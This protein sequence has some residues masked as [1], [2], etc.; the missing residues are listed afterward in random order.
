MNYVEN[1]EL[2]TIIMMKIKKYYFYA[3]IV[4]FF[5]FSLNFVIFFLCKF[6]AVSNFGS[7][8][9]IIKIMLAGFNRNKIK[10]HVIINY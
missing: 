6:T 5:T 9:S 8:S 2:K 4:I 3:I 7:R 1:L 10:N